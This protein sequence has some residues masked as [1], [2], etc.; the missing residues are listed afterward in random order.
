MS[1]G[2]RMKVLHGLHQYHPAIG[3]AENLMRE[4]SERLAARGH[5]VT[6]IAT[7]ARSTEDYLLPGRGKDLLP[8]GEETV[9]GVRV[10]RVGF[11]RKGRRA[12]VFLR[13]VAWRVPIPW[14][15]RWRAL[16]W[17]PRSREYRAAALAEDFDVAAGCPLP[18][19]NVGYTLEAA[20][21]KGRPVVVVPCF[22]TEDLYS[23]GNPIYY[24]WMRRA[25]AVVTLTDWE[26]EF[27]V[28]TARLDEAR[29]HT[30][31]VGIGDLEPE[32]ERAGG[33]AAVDVRAKYGIR[34][35]RIVLFLGQMGAH[36]GILTLITAMEDAW[37][38]GVD[39]ALVIAGNPTA[40]TSTIEARIRELD[41]KHGRR[42]TLV[43]G[44]PE[45]EKRA[46][47][48]AADLF[49]QVSPFESFGIV[50]L[51][52][53]RDGVPV[54]GCRRGGSAKLIDEFKDGLLALDGNSRELTAAIEILLADG[55][56]RK[57]MGEAGRRKVRERYAWDAVI[58]R[59]EELY[60]GLAG[61][62]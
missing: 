7:T 51:E 45:E 24:D 61:R 25:D 35:E 1:L 39:A 12:L 42:I 4:V 57:R 21:A 31:G 60:R 43:K 55:T 6:I 49:V 3:G 50:F 19:W 11:T 37:D 52:A 30:I 54:V 34:E 28:R 29:V 33:T 17:G 62:A 2:D 27:L 5:A 46:F 18:N 26:K 32:P 16:A 23:F 10:R 22:H 41:P 48:R 9:G 15:D 38:H 20:R 40:H 13:K 47:F 36:K 44:F 56:A 58:D 53:W 14:G 8:A 59:W